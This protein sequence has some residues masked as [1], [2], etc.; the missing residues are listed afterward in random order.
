MSAIAFPPKPVRDL[1][2]IGIKTP[3]ETVRLLVALQ[4]TAAAS[5]GVFLFLRYGP[6]L[7]SRMPSYTVATLTM[8]V[9]YCLSAPGAFMG[10]GAL[11]FYKGG[12]HI[13]LHL[14]DKNIT[15]LVISIGSMACSYIMFDKYKELHAPFLRSPNFLD[16][17]FNSIA[18]G[19]CDAVYDRFFNR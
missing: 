6:A 3:T 10:L 12:A 16:K 13:S 11:F 19:C 7:Q 9:G 17:Q 5:L 2:P 14:R 4:R 1:S 8:I 18:A 15:S